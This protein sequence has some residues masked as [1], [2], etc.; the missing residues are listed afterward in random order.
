MA[1]ELHLGW[2][3]A[4]DERDPAVLE[5]YEHARER[6]AAVLRAQFPQF[7]WEMRATAHR[8]FPPQGMLDP[9]ALLELGLREKTYHGWDYALVVVPNELLPRGRASVIGVPSSALEVAALSSARLELADEFADRLAGLALHLLGHLWG[10]DHDGAGPMAPP[11]DASIRRA[12]DFPPPQARAIAARLA[13]VADLRLEERQGR[14]NWLAFHWHTLRADPRGILRDIWGSAPW[15]LPLRMGRL[16]AAAAVSLVFLLLGAEAWEVGISFPAPALALGALGVVAAATTF[17]YWG[18]NLSQIAR[19]RGYHEQLTRTRIVL[20]ATLLVGMGAL[21]LV[22]F[23][24]A[25]GAALAVPRA[26]PS[27]WVGEPLGLAALARYAA[28]LAILG[29]VAGALGG[30][31]EDADAL[32]AQ[33]YFDEET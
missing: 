26:V 33:L 2:I 29:V 23:A 19:H 17:L 6:L 14:W 21:W 11:D 9:L 24:V 20:F 12:G 18:Q 5:A 13:D 22:L 1:P 27:G 15:W 30:N 32:K 4:A 16:T 7:R 8:S 25:L 10:L 31:L 3:L 28:F